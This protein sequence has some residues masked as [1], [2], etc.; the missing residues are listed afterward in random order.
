MEFQKERCIETIYS[1]AKTKG[2]KIGELEEKAGVSKGYLARINKE[3]STANPPIEVIV[4]IADQLDVSVDYLIAADMN[5]LSD[6]EQFV[7]D[8]A[9]KLKK[10]TLDMKMEWISESNNVLN[11]ENNIEVDNPLVTVEKNYTPEFDQMY[12][13]HVYRSRFYG[14]GEVIVVDNCYHAE[15]K[16]GNPRVYIN[17]VRY[18]IY[19]DDKDT[20]GEMSDDVIEIYIVKGSEI[21]PVCSTYYVKPEIKEAVESLYEV[22]SS[23]MSRIG[24]SRSTKDIMRQFIDDLL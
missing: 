19:K 1:L 24:L 12:D 8:F 14:Q 18:R 21:N 11:A 9:N 3:G 22:V 16:L 6:S 15:L 10:K 7:I 17:K 23:A 20:Y 2:L 4:S 13:C 5:T